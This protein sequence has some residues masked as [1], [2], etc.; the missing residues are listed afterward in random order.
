MAFFRDEF[1]FGFVIQRG[2]LRLGKPRF[3]ERLQ[4]RQV[5]RCHDVICQNRGFERQLRARVRV[6][7]SGLWQIFDCLKNRNCPACLGTG[8]GVN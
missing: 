2:L 6:E 8:R 7:F 1:E 4:V 3:A 5:V